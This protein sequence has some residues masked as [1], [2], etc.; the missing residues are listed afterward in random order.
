MNG[1]RYSPFLRIAAVLVCVGMI[2]AGL[3]VLE[4]RANVVWDLTPDM[5]TELSEGTL[6]TLGGLEETV[7]IHLVF[8]SETESTLRWML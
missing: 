7:S 1:I 8:K 2:C 4:K 6:Q 3:A 5:L